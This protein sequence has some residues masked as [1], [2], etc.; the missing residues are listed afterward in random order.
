MP[1]VV[2]P[3][4]IG[5]PDKP[6]RQ[7]GSVHENFIVDVKTNSIVMVV[8]AYVLPRMKELIKTLDVP[9]KM[10][11]IDVLLFEKKITDTDNFGMNLL[12]LGDAASHKNK[13]NLTW[14]ETSHE[15]RD[16]HHDRRERR[17]RNDRSDRSD[18]TDRRDRR[19]RYSDRGN[20]A[21]GAAD[22]VQNGLA[23]TARGILSFSISRNSH[24]IFPAYD[25]A[26]N[27]LLAQEDIQI[28]AN[29]SVVTVNQTPAKISIMDEISINTGVYD[30][31]ATNETRFKD[32][33]AR[34]QYGTTIN[35]T[36]TIHSQIENNDESEEQKF[37]TIATEVNFDTTH[38]SVDN[39]PDVTKRNIKNE[40]R[41]ADGETII[42]GGLRRK[43]SESKQ[44]SVPFLGE[45][46]WIG[47]FFSTTELRDASTEM[48]IFI[49]PKII[50]DPADKMHELRLKELQ[51]RPGDLPEF[52][53]ACENVKIKEREKLFGRTLKALFGKPEVYER[54]VSSP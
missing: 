24:G 27:F 1:P 18:R 48:F 25:L 38:P 46:P 10:V 42:L 9:K 49:T 33:F 2:N 14:N 12:K 52:L 34:A 26:F 17:D 31:N 13:T 50:P 30:I 37:I 43:S 40:V 20:V 8:E 53:A 29:P 28:N 11:Q 22:L 32:S 7:E 6:K 51:R 16:R 15:K 45:L 21:D 41:V 35:I 3:E 44:D 39:R 4:W 19:D 47:K 23:E 54:T 5:A 36:P